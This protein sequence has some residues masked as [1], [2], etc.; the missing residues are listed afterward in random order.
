MK[1]IYQSK[2]QQFQNQTYAGSGFVVFNIKIIIIESIYIEI[3]LDTQ[4]YDF[5]ISFYTNYKF[6]KNIL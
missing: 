2:A 4:S 5:S 6:Y 3:D 1:Q